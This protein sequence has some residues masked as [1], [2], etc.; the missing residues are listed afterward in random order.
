M[1]YNT[2]TI[3]TA[4]TPTVIETYF[5]HVWLCPL[6]MDPYRLITYIDISVLLVSQPQNPPPKAH[7][8]HLIPRRYQ[9][10]P[11]V[12]PLCIFAYYRRPPRF[13]SAMGPAPSLGQSRRSHHP[14]RCNRTSSRSTGGAAGPPRHR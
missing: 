3:A 7:R 10:D 4:V 2:L 9:S 6:P 1:V 13:H 11:P 12:S 8:S 14:R 5:S